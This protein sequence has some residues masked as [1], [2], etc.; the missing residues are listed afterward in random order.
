MLEICQFRPEEVGEAIDGMDGL[1]EIL[2]PVLRKAVGN[3]NGT[4]QDIQ[5]FQRHV[6]LAKHALAAM[7]ALLEERMGEKS[8]GNHAVCID[9]TAWKPCDTCMTCV[10][11]LFSMD[12]AE[13]WPCGCCQEINQFRSRAFCAK[14]GRP[15]TEEA[16][17]TLE[18]RLMRYMGVSDSQQG[19]DGHGAK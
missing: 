19:E 9:R 7:G 12:S 4:E 14:C 17:N 2:V 5:Q 18:Q 3:G 15:L 1:Q 16:W 13:D 8:G 11:C 6:M 10:N